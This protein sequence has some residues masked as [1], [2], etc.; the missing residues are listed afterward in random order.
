MAGNTV[1]TLVG[2]SLGILLPSIVAELQLSPLEAGWLGAA[3]RLGNILLA[4]PIGYLL[5]QHNPRLVMI[6]TLLGAALFTFGQ[7]VA[8]FFGAL[9]AARLLFGVAQTAR[10]PGRALYLVQ[11]FPGG[12]IVVANGLFI[13]ATGIAEAGTLGLTPFILQALGSW[14]L[15]MAVFGAYI[16]VVTLL[17]ILLAR[18]RVTRSYQ[19]ALAS[20]R[21]LS[22]WS[23]FRYRDLWLAGLGGFGASFG[24]WA[25]A[26]FWPTY[27][28][29]VYSMPL[30]LSGFLYGLISLGMTAAALAVG[31]TAS[32]SGRRRAVVVACGGLMTIGSLGLLATSFVPLLVLSA[33]MAGLA[34]GFVPIN[35]SVAYQIPGIKPRET[36]VGA[37]FVSTL[38]MAGGAAGPFVAGALY[39]VSG[40]LQLALVICALAP[41]GLTITGL[42]Q[43]RRR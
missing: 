39:Q 14:R 15:T 20:Q 29:D 27:M 8:P 32:S 22:V 26:T 7:A 16:L 31:W 19:D 11:W 17:F 1:F 12:Q 41:L 5:S 37:S 40:S 43:E 36:A 21:E 2:L 13:A 23:I 28:K 25:L 35:Q 10:S 24:W 4:L 3:F 6:A 18:Q 34:W 9:L 33:A 38:F 42:L 30:T